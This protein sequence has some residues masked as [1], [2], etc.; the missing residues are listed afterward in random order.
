MTSCEDLPVLH[1]QGRG[2]FRLWAVLHELLVL[3]GLPA[4]LR[5][6]GAL[7]RAAAPGGLAGLSAPGGAESAGHG[8]AAARHV[9]GAGEQLGPP[10]V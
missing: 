6:S 9:R 5:V 10:V 1:R 3:P 4:Q 2:A 7:S 8:L